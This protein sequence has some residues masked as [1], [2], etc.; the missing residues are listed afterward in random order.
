MFRAGSNG[1]ALASVCS[2]PKADCSRGV[3]VAGF[4]AGGGIAGR[5]RNFAA[6]VRAAWLLGVNGPATPEA[7][8]DPARSRALPNNR[9]QDLRGPLRCRRLH[10]AQRLTG[11]NCSASPCVGLDGSGFHVVEH[12]EVADG[13]AD[14]GWWP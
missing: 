8:A 6:Q 12:S 1:N 10:G 11:L 3:V 14:D 5:A 9:I 2:R 7:P 4:T 13:V